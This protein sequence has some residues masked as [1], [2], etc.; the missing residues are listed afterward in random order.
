[1]SKRILV[2]LGHPARNS[3]CAALSDSYINSAR[4]KGHSV[5]LLAL[6]NLAFDPILHDGYQQV[7]PLEPDLLQAQ[8][9]ISWA[10]HL[11]FIFPVWWGG[12]PALLKG[13]LDRILL[14]GFAFKYRSGSPFPEQ[15]LKGRSADLLVSMDTPPWYYRWVYRMPA[16]EQMRRT[17]LGFCGIRA[18][19]TLT[20][21]PVISSSE[22]Q[23][24]TWLQ[25][26]RTLARRH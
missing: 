21:G 4:D 3:F 13:F 15:L 6:G 22:R 17:T 23:R 26:A 12:I 5:C 18:K 1:M 25:Q 9:L 20:F 7:Q 10:E 8:Q 19:K 14:P 24:E 2:I 16:L 11:V